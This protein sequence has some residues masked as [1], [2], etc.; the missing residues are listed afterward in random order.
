MAKKSHHRVAQRQ[1][2]QVATIQHQTDEARRGFKSGDSF[3]N[4]SARLGYGAGSQQ[5]GA[6][7]AFDFISRNRVNLEAAYRS[8]WLCGQVVDTVANDMTRAGI[9]IRSEDID[10]EHSDAIHRAFT[11]MQLWERLNDLVKWSRL[12]GGAIAVMLVDGQNLATPLRKDTVRPG[13]FKGVVV[14]DRWQIQPTL[15]QLVDEYG[16]DLGKPKFYDVLQGASALQG[17]KVHYSRVIRLDG[18]ELPHWQRIAENGWGQSI[19]ERLWDRVIAFDSTTEGAAQLV[20]KAHLRTISIEGLRDIIASGGKAQEG[21]IKQMEMIRTFQSNEGLTI[22][23]AKDKFEAHSYTFSGLDNVLLQFGQQLS[24]ATQIPL[25]RL[26]GQSPAGLNSTGESDLRTYYDNINQQ[27]EAKLRPGVATLC[28]LVARSENGDGLPD[29]FDFAFASLWQMTDEQKA[30]VA[31]IGGEA[32]SGAEEKGII[33]HQTA[34]KE[35]RQLS[36]T[37]GYFTHISDDEINDAD[38]RPPAPNRERTGARRGPDRRRRRALDYGR[39][40]F[41]RSH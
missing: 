30:N 26:F 33:S 21:L 23:D 13:Q 15:M 20:F 17:A 41:A 8:N 5:D 18:L 6:R 2:Q 1:A 31:K 28:D 34:L 35:Y 11:R 16:P 40:R 24:G 32:I 19:L 38:D 12:Y 9:E 3:V 37:T 39:G 36:R 22:L 29:G 25:V 14:L 27:Q 7:F 10:P 4:F